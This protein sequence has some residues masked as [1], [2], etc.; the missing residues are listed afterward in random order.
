M[1]HLFYLNKACDQIV[2]ATSPI[3]VTEQ[4]PV[5]SAHTN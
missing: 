3:L 2:L 5:A 1:G 4:L